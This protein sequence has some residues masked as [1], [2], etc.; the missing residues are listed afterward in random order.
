MPLSHLLDTSILSQP[1]KDKPLADVLDRWSDLGD[2]RVCTSALCLAEIVQG[3]RDRESAKYWRR[4][5][6]L[7]ENQYQILSFDAAVADTFSSLASDLRRRGQ[8]KPAIDLM[9]A[10]T[11]SCHGLVLAT[12]NAR[13]FTGIPGLV[14]ENWGVTTKA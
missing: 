1:I 11:A 6:D 13:D 14:V 3:L 12:L 2:E 5:R 9:I 10:A 4:Y 8:P 7:I